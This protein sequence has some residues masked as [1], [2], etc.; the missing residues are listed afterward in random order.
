M[1]REEALTSRTNSKA[2]LVRRLLDNS[3]GAGS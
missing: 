2:K 1:S 3:K